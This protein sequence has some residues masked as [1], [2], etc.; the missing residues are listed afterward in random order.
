MAITLKDIIDLDYLVSRDEALESEKEIRLRDDRD[1]RI[2]RQCRETCR[3][4]EAVLRAW[5]EARRQEIYG[6]DGQKTVILLP[7][8]VF[9]SLYSFMV[10]GLIFLGVFSGLSLAW[11]F[12][13]YHGTRPVNVALFAFLFIVLQG[14]LILVT[15][16]FLFRR[17][18]KIRSEKGFKNSMVHTVVSFLFFYGLPGMLKKANSQL[19]RKGQDSLE[20]TTA[21]FRMKNREFQALF[22]WPIFILTSVFAFCFILG[23]LAGTFFRVIVSDMAFGWQSTL[24]ATSQSVYDLVSRMALPW[25]WFM[26]ETLAHPSLAQIEG[27]RIIL[28][29][30]IA[31]LATR[32]LVSWWPFLCL[33][34]LFYAVLPRGALL[35]T[36]LLAQHHVLRRFDLDRPIFRQLLI[37]MQS[38]NL[39]IESPKDFL[40]IRG[41]ALAP[42]HREE[43]QVGQNPALADDSTQTAGIPVQSALILAPQTVYSDAAMEKIE[44]HLR[45]GLFLDVRERIT[46]G[47]DPDQDR[48]IFARIKNSSV[49]QVVIV[50]E[51]WQP[52]IRG[53]LYYIRSLKSVMPEKMQL[54]ILLTGSAGPEN[55]G[56]EKSDVNFETWKK[57]VV[58]LED[59]GITVMRMV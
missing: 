24:M 5:L 54:W 49:D 45:A 29:D 37:R 59:P 2:Y 34:I 38:R 33:G 28:K 19:F 40:G 53:L 47:F 32:D 39:D 20:Y 16:F 58:T 43:P 7:G 11:S 44:S 41:P 4:P 21:L 1:R 52:P 12:L 8:T 48:E 22:F 46:A 13:A 17:R 50:Y 6:E 35:V 36:G 25:S 42:I 9:S 15:V 18:M 51:V 14:I 26:P 3:T 56:V 55:L 31:V 57:A 23:A 27:S 30:G 10:A